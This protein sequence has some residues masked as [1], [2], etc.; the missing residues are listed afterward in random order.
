MLG[1]KSANQA[2]KRGG[3]DEGLIRE[4]NERSLAISVRKHLSKS[5]GERGCQAGAPFRIDDRAN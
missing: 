1:V 3:I 5:C 4:R 2:R